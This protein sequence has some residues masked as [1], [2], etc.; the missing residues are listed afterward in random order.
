MKQRFVCI[1]VAFFAFASMFAQVASVKENEFLK[2]LT[3]YSAHEGVVR[4]MQDARLPIA[5]AERKSY[6]E[7]AEV[8]YILISGYRVQVY[9][10]NVPQTARSEAFSMETKVKEKMPDVPSY[11]SFNSPFW[12]VRLGD[13]RTY[14]DAMSLLAQVRK[15][16]PEYKNNCYIVKEDNIR[17][18]I[19]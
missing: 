13:C 2:N 8:P 14:Q 12:K 16:F 17:I 3:S 18:S 7:D 9:S 6:K 11:V 19:K 15:A 4:I 1:W 10:S 5:I